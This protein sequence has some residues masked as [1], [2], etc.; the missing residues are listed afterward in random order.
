MEQYL[1]PLMFS[2]NTS[3]HCSIK[4]THFFITFS[5]KPHLHSFPGQDLRQKFYS[6]SS[7]AEL[8]QRLL[9]GIGR[10]NNKNLTEE[11]KEVFNSKAEP[12][13]YQTHKLI[14]LYE[15]SFLHKK[16]KFAPKWSGPHRIF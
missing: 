9:R 15:H 8:H 3:F 13:H 1:C 6:E 2:H 5:L 11:N 16:T 10:R 12:H 4:T 7:L 14:L